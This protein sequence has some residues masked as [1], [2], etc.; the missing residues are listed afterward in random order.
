MIARAARL[1][2]AWVVAAVTFLVLLTAAGFRATPGVLII[3]LEHEFGWSSALIGGA[4]AVNLLVYGIGAPFAAA[5]VERFG[6]RRVCSIALVLVAVGASLTTQMTSAWQL[7]L[8]WGLV[9]GGAT[10]AIAVP[11]AAI[12]ANRWFDRR[13]GLVTGI[14]TSSNASGQLVFLPL[15]AWVVTAYSWR[16]AALVVAGA[17]LFLVLPLALIFLRS[18]PSDIGLAPFGGEQVLPAPPLQNPFRNAVTALRDAVRV[19]DFWLLAG[20]FFICGATTNGLIGTHLIA[21]CSDH[22]LSQVRGAGLLAAIGVFDVIGTTCS[23]WLTDRYDPRWLLFW[24]YGLRGISL[25]GLNAALSDAGL[26]LAAF[27]VF[28]GLDWVATVPPT[29]ALCRQAFGRERVGVVFA[30]VFACHQFGAAFAAWGAGASRTWLHSYQ[31]AFL[32]AGSLGVLA[33]ALSLSVGRRRLVPQ[34]ATT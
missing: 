2:Y 7:Y 1:H 18:R 3:P 5:V 16:A 24:Y 30:W 29:V 4:V 6:V 26:G 14:L 23:G 17:A 9:V 31:P 10:G 19:R 27:T 25:L 33:A 13:R 34:P 20:A 21:A 11:L 32:I 28:Y 22:G 15:M 12:V 8:L